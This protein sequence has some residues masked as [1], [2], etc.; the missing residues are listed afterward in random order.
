MLMA[1]GEGGGKLLSTALALGRARLPIELVVVCG[2][3]EPLEQKLG[4]LSRGAADADART[5]LYR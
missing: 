5:R 3:N 1:G 4:E 2:R